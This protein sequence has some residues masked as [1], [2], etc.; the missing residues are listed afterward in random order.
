MHGNQTHLENVM[1]EGNATW[2]ITTYSDLEH[3]FTEWSSGSYSVVADVRSWNA[4]KEVFDEL[5]VV[6]SDIDVKSGGTMF[7]PSVLFLSFFLL[8]NNF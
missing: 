2:E 7:Y 5:L 4:M 6:E 3:G 1:N 8:W